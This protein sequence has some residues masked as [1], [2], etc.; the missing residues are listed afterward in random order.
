MIYKLE[1]RI[2]TIRR[3]KIIST[4]T[5]YIF[6]KATQNN[7]QN[8]AKKTHNI[9]VEIISYT[10]FPTGKLFATN[11][12]MSAKCECT[13]IASGRK[14]E[15]RDVI[16]GCPRVLNHSARTVLGMPV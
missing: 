5:R 1:I 2:N 16:A 10:I 11:Q 6:Q 14:L 12:G 9:F 3:F 13:D 15:M 7:I 8:T 4:Q